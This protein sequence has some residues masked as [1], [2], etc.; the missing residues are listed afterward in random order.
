MENFQATNTEN[1]ISETQSEPTQMERLAAVRQLYS[2][3]KVIQA[4]QIGLSVL[5]PPSLAMLVAFVSLPPVYAAICGIILTC[6]YVLW[7]TPWLQSFKEK[8]S[9][10]QELFDCD[11]LELNRRELTIGSPLEM[12]DIVGEYSSKYGRKDPNYCELKNW[13]PDKT[14]KLPIHLG[15]VIC[16]RSNCSWDAKLRQRFA[17]WILV[18]LGVLIVLTLCLGLIGN[19]TL[20]E[21]ILAVAT[22]LM[23]AFILGMRQYNEHKKSAE[24]LD[25]LRGHLERLWNK[26]LDNANPEELNRASRELQDAIY[27]HRQSRP[28]IFD[29]VYRLLRKE[30]EKL[31]NK[32]AEEMVNEALESLR[33]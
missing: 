18:I 9:K 28:I 1:K 6:V 5:V 16:Q 17:S 15:R 20:E 31:M 27:N 33:E 32:A 25:K 19:L 11:V 30:H 29:W 2:D 23:P 24:Q 3:A 12:I 26:A 14:S 21:F 4:I 7:L 8:A 13:Y 10:I 22:P